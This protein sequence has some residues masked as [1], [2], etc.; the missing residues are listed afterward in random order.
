M[1]R[2]WLAL[3]ALV[4]VALAGVLVR[5]RQRPVEAQR[6]VL[7]L[8]LSAQPTQV[9]GRGQVMYTLT[10]GNSD[11]RD[12][13][14]VRVEVVLPE[15][16][17]YVTDSAELAYDGA[18]AP[19]SNPTQSGQ[20]LE[21]NLPALPGAR[22]ESPF[23]MHTF[24]QDKWSDAAYQLDRVREL[25]GPG[26]FVKQLCYRITPATTG[27]EPAWVSFVNGC[28]DRGL[29]PIIRLAGEYDGGAGHWVKPV[30]PYDDMAQAFKRVVAGL[31]RRDGHLLYVEIWNEPNLD[32]EWGGQANPVEYAQ[33]LVATAAAVRSLGDSRIVLMNGGLSPGVAYSA[34]GG[35][36]WLGFIDAMATVPGALDSFDVWSSHAYPGNRPPEQNLHVGNITGYRELTI[37]AFRLELERLALQGRPGVDVLITETG[38]ALGACDFCGIYGLPQIGEANRAD[39]MVRAYRDWW[40]RWP[41]VRG[42]CPYQLKDSYGQWAVWD[43]IG[44]QQYDAVRAMDKTVAPAP[45]VLTLRFEATA[46]SMSGTFPCDASVTTA[47]LGSV[48][49]SGVAPVEVRVLPTPTPVPPGEC[50]ELLDDGDFEQQAWQIMETAYRA[51]Y[52]TAVVRSGQRALQAGILEGTPVV[53]YSSAQQTVH[54]PQA[55]QGVTFEFWYWP[56]A[57]LSTAG[58]QYVA[59]LNDQGQAVEYLMWQRNNAQTWLRA[60]YDLSHYVGQTVTLRF[61]AYNSQA[62]VDS[63]LR[64]AMVV[65]DASLRVC[66]AAAPLEGDPMLYMPH[67]LRQPTPTPTPKPTVVA[68]TLAP[69]VEQ[70]TLANAESVSNDKR[71]RVLE[72]LFDLG[73]HTT[74]QPAADVAYDAVRGR[75]VAA[76]GNRVVAWDLATREQLWIRRLP[77]EA[78]RIVVGLADGSVYAVLPERGEVHRFSSQGQLVAVAERLRRPTEVVLVGGRLWVAETAQGRLSI[79]DGIT[80]ATVHTLRLPGIP[81]PLAHVPQAGRVFVA[82][83]ESGCVLA[84]NDTTLEPVGMAQLGGVGLVSELV[85]AEGTA[86]LYAAHPLSGRYG[87]VSLV[88]AE[89]ID[90]TRTVWGNPER[91][92]Q[93]ANALVFDAVRDQVVLREIGGMRVLDGVTLDEIEHVSGAGY[94]RPGALAL[95]R[96]SGTVFLS[97][98]IG[99]LWTFGFADASP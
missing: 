63:G 59:V 78:Y 49:R 99:R 10:L 50:V 30:P 97:D 60:R 72:P 4:L 77:A 44:H 89:A 94:G 90:V 95:D 48:L 51:R 23:G 64:T 31:P 20:R 34:S 66:G 24:V 65:D 81:G 91:P 17:S 96:A 52:T 7:S 18:T 2:V 68:A 98:S 84:L 70:V 39:Y 40:N 56:L 73:L 62:N 55:E 54:I 26:A 46:G 25:M 79:L 43:W 85:A 53:S 93:G 32:L 82:M 11:A 92:L 57:E 16:F 87:G 36:D 75:L 19:I 41:E 67:L 47:N 33:F 22:I 1:R 6:S 80:L 42:V 58:L 13:T 12:G 5:P 3:P 28:Y 27:P 61:G 8:D 21:W 15:G 45:R 69:E 29:V 35:Y 76:V 83:H 88:D 38:Y 37:D 9:D 74:G 71:Q 14:S 86:R